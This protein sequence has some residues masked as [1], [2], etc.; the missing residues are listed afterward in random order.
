MQRGWRSGLWQ[1]TS[2]RLAVVQAGF[3][4]LAMTGAGVAMSVITRG[5]AERELRS[6]IMLESN[7][8]I[9]ELRGEGVEEA[10]AAVRSRAARPGALEYLLIDST[11]RHLAGDLPNS[12]SSGWHH[13]LVAHGN[14]ASDMI[15]YSVA[16]PGGARLTVGDDLAPAQDLA[17]AL[18]RSLLFWGGLALCLGLGF[19]IWA[20]RRSLGRMQLLGRTL[21]E[22]SAGDLSARVPGVDVR[23][24]DLDLVGRGI[25]AMLDRIALLVQA[26]RRV[27]ADVAHEL[28]NPLALVRQ[29][30]ARAATAEDP[31]DRALA[32]AAADASI[33]DALRL[34]DAMLRLAEI[35]AGSARQR[36]A[37]FDLG[38]RV[39][40]VSD[41]YRADIEN[42]GRSLDI[43]L[44]PA[45]M[46]VG[47]SDLV[48]LAVAN[49]FDNAIK[50]TPPGASI[51]VRV[52]CIG[53]QPVL[54]FRDEGPGMSAAEFARVVEPFARLDVARST[55]GAGLGLAIVAAVMRLHGG[56]FER[57]E[58]GG[59][60]H[61][62]CRFEAPRAS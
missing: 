2:F 26:Q 44:A 45:V 6:R 40:L 7:A 53:G 56:R 10:A 19:G 50:H 32:L 35:E 29:R 18:L 61:L 11:G 28:R 59:G 49:L 52:A 55:S 16:A 58:A 51:K 25:N 33:G 48:G 30:I 34:F 39:E 47:D 14:M 57:V 54:G 43:D 17:D 38:E 1:S 20:T 3:L 8:I 24:D 22:V 4:L 15:A 36:F 60:L 5:V 37:L 27:S 21:D 31:A 46:L 12:P 62:Q 41:A 9:A 23:G 13:M 42:A